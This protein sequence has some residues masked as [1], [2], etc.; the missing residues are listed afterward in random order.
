MDR[1]LY[2]HGPFRHCKTRQISELCHLSEHLVEPPGKLMEDRRAAHERDL[3]LGK[4][5]VDLPHAFARKS[6]KA[7]WSLVWQYMFAAY[8]LSR[9][10]ET[11]QRGRRG[12]GQHDESG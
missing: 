6:P 1:K 8:G 3:A 11:G 12:G 2:R 10:P 9:H 5:C 7:V 4:G